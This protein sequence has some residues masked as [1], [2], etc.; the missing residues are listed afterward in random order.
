LTTIFRVLRDPKAYAIAYILFHEGRKTMTN[1][2]AQRTEPQAGRPRFPKEYSVPTD[3][4][5]PWQHARER[6]EA[7]RVYWIVTVASDGRPYVTPLWGAWLDDRLYFDGHPHTR[8][9]RNLA[10]NKSV[11]VHLEGGG[12]GSD[13]VIVEGRV[14]D[15]P[16]VDQ[17]HAIRIATAFAAKYPETKIDS[18]VADLVKRGLF[19]M[20][21]HRAIA[22]HGPGIQHATRWRFK[23]VP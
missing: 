20:E 17:A 10:H 14:N 2:A 11:A 19:E 18:T 12:D 8:W 9:A 13:V 23:P 15:L 22:W 3:D 1:P 5:L 6:L 4:L 21:L 7:A 16:T